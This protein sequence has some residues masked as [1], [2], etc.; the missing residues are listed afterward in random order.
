MWRRKEE[1]RGGREVKIEREQ[2]ET[3]EGGK[4]GEGS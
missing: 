1:R 2:K 3:V 4:Y